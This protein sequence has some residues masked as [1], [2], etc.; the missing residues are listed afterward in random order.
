MGVVTAETLG[1]PLAWVTSSIARSSYPAGP[2]S[3]GSQVSAVMAPSM[4]SAAKNALAKLLEAVAAQNGGKAE[5]YAVKGG[6]VLKEGKPFAA[7]KAVCAKLPGESVVGE[8][9]GGRGRGAGTGSSRAAQFVEL[10]V[11]TETG[12]VHLE[13]VVAIQCCGKVLCRKTAESQIIGGVIQGLSYA[14]FEDRVLDRNTA[15]MLNP[16]LEMYKLIG[17]KDMPHIEPVLYNKGFTRVCPIGEPT[18]VPTA[19][20]VACA[21]FNAIGKPVRSLP[22]TPD[23]VLAALEGGAA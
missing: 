19:G 15:A 18:H 17:P 22:M 9:Q 6:E 21:I 16:N 23:K 4:E 14:L 20:A 8:A 5:D 11:D 2:A 10:T 1:V 7:F 3:G 12:R 13:R